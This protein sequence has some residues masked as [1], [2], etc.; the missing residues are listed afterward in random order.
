MALMTTSR[1]VARPARLNRPRDIIASDYRKNANERIKRERKYSIE[2]N[3]GVMMKGCYCVM[4]RVD[5][6]KSRVG[7]Q[8]K[9]IIK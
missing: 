1:R 3:D 4:M 2:V 8:A 7:N 5:T 6:T 9:R